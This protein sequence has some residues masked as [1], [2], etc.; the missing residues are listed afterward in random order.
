MRLHRSTV[1]KLTNN[2]ELGYCQENRTRA[3]TASSLHFLGSLLHGDD[4]GRAVRGLEYERAEAALGDGVDHVDHRVGAWHPRGVG[5]TAHGA[6]GQPGDVAIVVADHLPVVV[7]ALGGAL[8]A[9][10]PFHRTD[11]RDL[12]AADPA[13]HLRHE[14][15]AVGRAGR[16]DLRAVPQVR[17]DLAGDHR[18]D[19]GEVQVYLDSAPVLGRGNRDALRVSDG[20]VVG[21]AAKV[22][23][24][25]DDGAGVLRVASDAAAAHHERVGSVVQDLLEGCPGDVVAGD[26]HDGRF[27][28]ADVNFDGGKVLLELRHFGSFR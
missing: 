23:V 22:E 25:T 13:L 8:V 9:G 26:E 12:L 21:L 19:R 5:T 4:S 15:E 6:A 17:P 27:L 20:V 24:G 18:V 1:P 14:S 7:L 11:A 2:N 16:V 10:L 28:V 3:V